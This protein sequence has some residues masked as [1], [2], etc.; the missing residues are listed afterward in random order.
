MESGLGTKSTDSGIEDFV[1]QRKESQLALLL[2]ILREVSNQIKRDR[3]P[4]VKKARK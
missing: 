3:E 4:R 2:I 1:R